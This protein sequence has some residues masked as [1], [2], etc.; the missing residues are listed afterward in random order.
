MR[1]AS[2][3]V[4]CVGSQKFEQQKIKIPMNLIQQNV[5]AQIEVE[6]K[7][8]KKDYL[9]KDYVSQDEV[10]ESDGIKIKNTVQ[11]YPHTPEAVNSYADGTNYRNDINAAV[12]RSAPGKNIVDVAAL[13]EL[14][15]KSPEQ[16]TEFFK[17]ALQKIY[18]AKKTQEAPA[19]SE[20]KDN[21]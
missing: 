3:D 20:V 13:Q 6:H 11:E 1:K 9:V 12:A 10:V 21:G 17:S 18:E 16:V 5:Y 8:E 4:F 19:Q 14:F 15:E 2:S 7:D